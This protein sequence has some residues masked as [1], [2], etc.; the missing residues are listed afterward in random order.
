M[1]LDI[2]V[3]Y[4]SAELRNC[5]GAPSIASMLSK[6]STSETHEQDDELVTR[7]IVLFK[8][9]QRFL[10]EQLQQEEIVAIINHA[11]REAYSTDVRVSI[12]ILP[13]EQDDPLSEKTRVEQIERR[14][15]YKTYLASRGWALK[16]EGVRERS[17][18]IC[19]RCQVGNHDAT[20][21]LTYE[22]VYDE[23]LDDLMGVCF[24]CH[25]YLSGKSDIDPA[26]ICHQS[27]SSPQPKPSRKVR[28][29]KKYSSLSSHPNYQ[30]TTRRDREHLRKMS[31]YQG[32]AFS[33]EDRQPWALNKNLQNGERRWTRWTLQRVKAHLRRLGYLEPVSTNRRRGKRQT[34]HGKLFLLRIPTFVYTGEKRKRADA[35]IEVADGKITVGGQREN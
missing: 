11:A 20:H 27:S 24:G 3:Q 4:V 7:V 25:E 13:H 30:H 1:S 9:E 14:S 32:I 5:Q 35:R 23:P 17:G 34:G 12:K 19:E 33:S 18:G 22:N 6:Y 16:R 28:R 31:C 26:S 8:E 21:H 10:A 2:D 15:K 29:S